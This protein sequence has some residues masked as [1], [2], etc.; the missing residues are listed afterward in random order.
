MH[1]YILFQLYNINKHVYILI[2]YTH[3]TNYYLF[4]YNIYYIY[5]YT[6]ANRSHIYICCLKKH[7]TEIKVLTRMTPSMDD[8]H[9][10][11]ET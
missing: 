9:R 6:S 11:D 7:C 1:L 5:I 8:Y 2:I 10:L 3:Y 4:V